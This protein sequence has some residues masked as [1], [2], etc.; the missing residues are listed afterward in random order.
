MIKRAASTAAAGVAKKCSAPTAPPP[1]TGDGPALD[2]ADFEI[3][4]PL[5]EAGMEAT[6]LACERGARSWG[7]GR[8]PIAGAA[9]TRLADGALKV[10]TVGHNCRIPEPGLE[11]GMESDIGY[12]TDHGETAATRNIEDMDAVD[13]PATVFATTLSPCIMCASML[14]DLHARGCCSIVIAEATSFK[15]AEARL[16]ALP[17]MRIVRLSTP[18]TVRRMQNFARRYPWQWAADVGEIPARPALTEAIIAQA[19]AEGSKW[20]AARAEGTAA[21]LG[22]D[23]VLAEASDGRKASGG[24]PCRAAVISAMG[25]AGS[26]VNLREC[27]VVWRS[28]S[29]PGAADAEFGR[30]SLG[31]C[32]L[33]RPAVLV[34]GPLDTAVSEP[35]EAAGIVV[36]QLHRR[37]L[38]RSL[39]N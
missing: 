34:T 19:K 29:T 2:L 24:N 10:V 27:A 13:W 16:E 4:G 14:E 21:V 12:P 30:A 1:R 3:L 32:V 15:G 23:G 33:F 22:C 17:G 36:I 28:G 37:S 8:V 6:R 11:E 39:L 38:R 26:A 5:A 7:Q 9:V 31:A 35:L 25:Q 20:L 18:D